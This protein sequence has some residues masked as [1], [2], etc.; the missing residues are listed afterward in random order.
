MKWKI[1][2]FIKPFLEEEH[3]K[4]PFPKGGGKIISVTLKLHPHKI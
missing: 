1:I 3:D 2:S 4:E